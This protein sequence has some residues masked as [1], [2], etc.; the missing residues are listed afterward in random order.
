MYRAA[1]DNELLPALK[2]AQARDCGPETVL[3]DS[4]YGSDDN[5]LAAAECGVEVIAPAMGTEEKGTK[6]HFSDF[7]YD[8]QKRMVTVYPAGQAPVEIRNEK[9]GIKRV[10]FD[11]GVCQNCPLRDQCPS[12][13]GK[14]TARFYYNPKQI[15]LSM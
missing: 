9:D 12:R 14:R 1:I 11:V 7:T 5:V 13:V 4:L 6:L 10:S 8:E 15:R 3:A 2:S